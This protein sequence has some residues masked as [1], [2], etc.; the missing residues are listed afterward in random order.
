MTTSINTWYVPSRALILPSSRQ[1]SAYVNDIFGALSDGIKRKDAITT[2]IAGA[3]STIGANDNR[4]IVFT[5]TS[6]TYTLTLPAGSQ[7][8]PPIKIVNAGT[9]NVITIATS[10][11]DKIMSAAPGGEITLRSV[12][13]Y[14]ELAYVNSTIGWAI[15]S[16]NSGRVEEA[17]ANTT[18]QLN[19]FQ[20]F[21]LENGGNYAIQL[22]LP[23]G[24][25]IGESIDLSVLADY[26]LSASVLLG[27]GTESVM[28]AAAQFNLT[29][30][31]ASNVSTFRLVRNQTTWLVGA[32]V[33]SYP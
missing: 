20:R 26:S 12:G 24:T 21:F 13:D 22:H 29:P 4:L 8:G 16:I 5:G 14:I 30:Y 7:N 9:G 17:K 23:T 10:G 1:R 18:Y 3:A 6:L 15:I 32:Y 27:D 33:P 2:I 31:I 19:R 11:S 25:Q 28:G